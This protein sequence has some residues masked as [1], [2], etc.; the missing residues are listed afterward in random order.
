MKTILRSGYVLLKRTYDS[1]IDF[2]YTPN[3]QKGPLQRVSV[4]QDTEASRSY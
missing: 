4:M 2:Y 1:G 3:H